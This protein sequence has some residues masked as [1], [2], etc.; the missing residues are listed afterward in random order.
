[1]SSYQPQYKNQDG[2]IVDLPLNADTLGGKNASEFAASSHTHS[3]TDLTNKPT[4]SLGTANNANAPTTD[5]V[6]VLQSIS[7][8]DH[9]ITPTNI[10]L[11]TKQYVD[12]RVTGAVSYLGTVSNADQLAA[13]NPDS[14]GDF[15]RVSTAFGNYHAGDLLLCE[16]IKS[17]STAATWS[18]IHG[19]MDKNTWTKNTKDA[20]GYVKKGSGQANKVWKTDAN[21]VPDW[22]DDA[23]SDTKVTQNAVNAL[24]YTNFR[25]LIFGSSNSS[26]EGFAPSTVTDGV[27][28]TNKFYVQPSTGTLAATIFKGDKVKVSNPSS[29]YSVNITNSSVG[30]VN[31]SNTDFGCYYSYNKIFLDNEG[32]TYELDIPLK[33]GTLATTS[34]IPTVITGGSQTTT[35]SADGGNNVYTFTKSD[36]TTSTLTVKNGSKGSTGTTGATGATGAEGLG[37][38]FS[39]TFTSTSTTSISI[40]TITVPSGRSLKI[41]DLIIAN[42]T[43]S[44][45]YR[46]TAVG[47]STVTIKYLNSLRGATGTVDILSAYPVGSIYMSVIST[48]PAD[49]FGGSWTRISGRFLLGLGSNTANT[50]TSY[51]SLP[52]G[53]IN[54]T[55][56]QEQGGEVTHK[57]TISEMPAHSHNYKDYYNVLSGAT[58]NSAR[59]V[60]AYEPEANLTD[61]S[62]AISGS[63]TTHNNM[64]PYFT[65][66][67]WRRTE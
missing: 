25:P 59:K 34:D 37:I 36:G 47:S 26:T 31:N 40:S 15:C 22:R 55:T 44:Y 19:E 9:K 7:V 32:T 38:F 29:S 62:T 67:M 63:G 10:T 18:L 2:E 35:S 45:L 28:S 23:N 8:S 46:V 60:V 6:S 56:V 61:Q 20:D 52:A 57:L 33:T 30:V 51:G 54:R 39:T 4:L 48:S 13:L 49:L 14:P 43:H 64:P 12:T 41:G 65:V 42:S 53:A 17:G 50:I 11:P 58:G 27:Y 3:Y 21:G 5:E 24:D 1:M 16:T 66:Y